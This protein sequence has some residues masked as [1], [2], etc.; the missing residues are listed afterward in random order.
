MDTKTCIAQFVLLLKSSS[1]TRGL[2]DEALAKE[3]DTTATVYYNKYKLTG[4]YLSDTDRDNIINKTTHNLNSANNEANY[5]SF[6]KYINTH[7]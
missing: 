3:Y 4:G 1:H 2:T 6:I 7:V 5:V